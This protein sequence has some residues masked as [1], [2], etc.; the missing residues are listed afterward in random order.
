M[1]SSIKRITTQKYRNFPSLT[2]SINIS[3]LQNIIIANNIWEKSIIK[4]LNRKLKRDDLEEEEENIITTHNEKQNKINKIK[5]DSLHK[6]Y[7]NELFNSKYYEQ[8]KLVIP[9]DLQSKIKKEIIK[10][11]TVK[12]KFFK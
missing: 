8:V 4:F 6:I 2:Q 11:E 3:D 9:K 10:D 1:S 5:G 7:I 12:L